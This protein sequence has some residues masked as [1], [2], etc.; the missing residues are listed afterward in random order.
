M[1]VSKGE[2]EDPERKGKDK[3]REEFKGKGN[4]VINNCVCVSMTMRKKSS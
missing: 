4:Y 3:R 2:G 1:G